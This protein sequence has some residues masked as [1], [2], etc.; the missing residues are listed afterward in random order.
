MNI[1]TLRP[2]LYPHSH[3]LISKPMSW[4]QSARFVIWERKISWG[5]GVFHCGAGIFI[6]LYFIVLAEE[7]QDDL[8]I[9]SSLGPE[10][11]SLAIS[12]QF[13]DNMVA[14][15]INHQSWISCVLAIIG[16][17]RECKKNSSH[18]GEDSRLGLTSQMGLNCWHLINVMF[19]HFYA[20]CHGL[21][22]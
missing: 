8:F 4:K 15:T 9:S 10:F 21:F 5:L 14:Y 2:A 18:I 11:W 7:L 3:C 16:L 17:K 13:F 1:N 20:F 19:V 12:S 6:G 22:S